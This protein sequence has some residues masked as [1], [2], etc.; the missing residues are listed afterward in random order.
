[1]RGITMPFDPPLGVEEIDVDAASLTSA[2][3]IISASLVRKSGM[4][5]DKTLIM[6]NWEV[7][8]ASLLAVA[9]TK[10]GL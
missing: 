1:M 4:N 3:H 5:L 8:A 10:T 7:T 2:T 9:Q 6:H